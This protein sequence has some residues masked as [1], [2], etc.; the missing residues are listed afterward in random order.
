MTP[1]IK[2]RVTPRM[3]PQETGISNDKFSLEDH[4]FNLGIKILSDEV[5]RKM[6]NSQKK[7]KNKNTR[8][9]STMSENEQK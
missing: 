8:K 1:G 3:C 9:Q 2:V 5:P 6:S 4:N 7:N